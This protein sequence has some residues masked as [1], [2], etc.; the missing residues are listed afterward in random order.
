MMLQCPDM[1]KFINRLLKKLLS[2]FP[3]AKT[4]M[5]TIRNFIKQR[6]KETAAK[7]LTGKGMCWMI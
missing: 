6:Q 7:S 2:I 3:L 4:L 5:G 1:L